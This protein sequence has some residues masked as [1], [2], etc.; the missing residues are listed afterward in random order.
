M[1]KE[2]AYR[3]ILKTRNNIHLQNIGK[4]LDTVKN[5]WLNKVKEMIQ[6]ISINWRGYTVITQ[7]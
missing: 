5:K 3:K 4:Y 2:V 6:P 7:C 1:N